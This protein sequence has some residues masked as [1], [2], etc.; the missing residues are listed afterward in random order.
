MVRVFTLRTGVLLKRLEGD[1]RLACSVHNES[2]F[3][4]LV[5][6]CAV[7]FNCI[8]RLGVVIGFVKFY[9]L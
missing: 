1:A 2:K 3:N 9:T 8:C 7:A 6:F 5:D 4:N